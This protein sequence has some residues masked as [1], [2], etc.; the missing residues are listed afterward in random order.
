MALEGAGG[1]ISEAEPSL[2]LPFTLLAVASS[3]LLLTW[4]LVLLRAFPAP[5]SVLVLVVLTELAILVVLTVPAS[6]LV[7]VMLLVL[8]TLP[9]VGWGVEVMLVVLVVLLSAGQGSSS[10]DL[11]CANAQG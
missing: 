1:L 10:E 6:L 9:E 7:L 11:F 4:L 8:V 3:Q 5:A 2:L